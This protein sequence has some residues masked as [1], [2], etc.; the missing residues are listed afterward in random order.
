MPV[1]GAAQP[2]RINRYV[3]AKGDEKSVVLYWYQSRDRVIASEYAAKFWLVLDSMRYHRSDT[4]L[5]RVIVP[6][7]GGREQDAASTAI[8]FVQTIFPVLRQVLPA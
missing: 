8:R 1:A 6:N 5:V 3:I 2:I 4:S 7:A